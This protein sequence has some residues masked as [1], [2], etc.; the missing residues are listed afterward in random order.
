MLLQV[1]NTAKENV[2]IEAVTSGTTIRVRRGVGGTAGAILVDQS[3]FM[4]GNAYEEAS[5]RPTALN[6]TPKRI[7][8]L[9]QIF[10]NTW[11]LSDTVRATE[12]IAGDTTTSESK[13]DCAALHAQSI[14]AA[15]FFGKKFEG[16]RKGQPFRTMDGLISII[17]NINNYPESY[18]VPNVWTAAGTTN[19]TQLEGFLDPVFNQ[20]TDPKVANERMLFV[21]GKA[22]SVINNIG[23]LNGTY[24]I[25]NGE[26][27][28]GLQFSQFKTSRGTFRMVE[29]PLFNSNPVWGAMAVAVD[30]TSF[31][32]A[33]LKGRKTQNKEFNT[34]GESAA[35]FGIDAVGGTLT[36]ECT[37]LVKNPPANA[38]ITGLTAAA[39][40]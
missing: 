14:E 8:N 32:M 39:Q 7:T 28:F 31:K 21:G 27:S 10:R 13:Q 2:L 9:T 22:R 4:V 20:T 1:N 15:L 19:Y 18:S 36:T 38:I 40:G 34:S 11:A 6:V 16:V 29:H 35:D 30:L 17:S 23:R 33:Y 24:F 12:V 26:T 25:E 5:I 37:A 3:A